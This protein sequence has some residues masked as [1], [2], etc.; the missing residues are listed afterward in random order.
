MSA[1]TPQA[2]VT[3]ITAFSRLSG[4]GPVRLPSASTLMVMVWP[5]FAGVSVAR[6]RCVLRGVWSSGLGRWSARRRDESWIRRADG[7]NVD[8]SRRRDERGF[9]RVGGEV[10]VLE[11][12][13]GYVV[14]AG[15]QRLDLLLQ[16][17]MR[18]GA[19]RGRT[20]ISISTTAAVSRTMVASMRSLGRIRW[21]RLH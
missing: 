1:Q 6:R 3:A 21:F 15:A 4:M 13:C 5:T 20:G 19:E 2:A 18:G 12:G 10:G 11:E 9:G 7:T 8:S 14:H 16:P 17:D